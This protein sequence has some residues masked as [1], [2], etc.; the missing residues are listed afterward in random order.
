GATTTRAT[1]RG[2]NSGGDLVC[3][4]PNQCRSQ[5][6]YCGTG[7]AYCGAGCQAGPCT[8]SGATTTRATTRGGNT[9]DGS[10]NLL[11][12]NPFVCV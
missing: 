2:G 7:T 11:D 6:G 8:G 1:T 4:D 9:G 10:G 5:W 12:N 3:P